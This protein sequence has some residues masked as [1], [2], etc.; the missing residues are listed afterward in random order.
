MAFNLNTFVKAGGLLP[1]GFTGIVLLIQ[2][3]CL[4]YGNFHLPFSLAYYALNLAPAVV[5]FIYVGKKFTLYS[6]LMVL[7]TGFL[8][9]W[10][11]SMFIDMIQ[12]HDTL[13]SAVFGGVL[14]AVS[15]SLCLYADATSGGTD[16]IAI[17]LSEK[18]RRDSWNQIFVGN[19]VILASAGFLFSLD[20]ALYSIIFQYVATVSLGVLYRNYQQRTLLVITNMPDTVS[21]MI[22]RKTNHGATLIDGIGS[23]EKKHRTVLYSVVTA[24]EVKE[25]I[26]AIREIDKDAF[27]NVLKTEL[28]NGRFYQRPKK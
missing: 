8:T 23:F 10:M 2:E 18:F 11:P 15:I 24:S 3:I 28:L 5:C 21:A 25:L 7:L 12:L 22:Y 9:D 26:P 27:I 17:F 19:C 1:G 14:Y 13:L 16:F 6:F 4:R 20:K